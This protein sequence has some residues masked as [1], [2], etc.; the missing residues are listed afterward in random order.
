MIED[1]TSFKSTPCIHEQIEDRRKDVNSP[2]RILNKNGVYQHF[3]YN[4]RF[5]VCVCEIVNVLGIEI[6]MENVL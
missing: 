2:I 1:P 4:C 6:L 3:L 5:F